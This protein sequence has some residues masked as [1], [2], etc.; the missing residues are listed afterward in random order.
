MA[1]IPF[2]LHLSNSITS[3][4]FFLRQFEFLLIV[5]FL[6]YLWA[7]AYLSC[8]CVQEYF[9]FRDAEILGKFDQKWVNRPSRRWVIAAC[10]P[11]SVTPRSSPHAE[12]AR[13]LRSL[14]E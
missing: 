3:D 2:T 12:Y 14:L 8:F 10:T 13:A 6:W 5:T 4:L 7:H 9:I 11:A 1:F